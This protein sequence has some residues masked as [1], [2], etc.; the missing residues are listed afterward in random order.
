MSFIEA[1][2]ALVIA[3]GVVIATLEISRNGAGRS[4]MMLMEMEAALIAEGQNEAAF[5]N[6]GAPARTE[7]ANGTGAT[8]VT[9]ISPR[10]Y[11]RG[12]RP[13]TE[14]STKVTVHRA[15]MAIERTLSTLRFTRS[16]TP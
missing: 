4:A 1:L 2:V 3:S 12:A 8:W 16:T 11:G 5:G 14:I 10:T 7:G 13:L 9:T 15:G 6:P